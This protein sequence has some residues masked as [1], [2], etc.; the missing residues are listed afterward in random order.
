[1]KKLIV[2]LLAAV[3][4]FSLAACS[5]N[6]T[7]PTN[8]TKPSTTDDDTP[9]DKTADM[10]KSLA[11]GLGTDGYI[12][13]AE[14]SKDDLKNVYGLDTDKITSFTAKKNTKFEDIVILLQVKEGYADKAVEALNK[15]LAEAVNNAR[16]DGNAASQKLLGA[17]LY[18]SGNYVVYVIAGK[19]YV[20]T[21]AAEE[22][23]VA[24]IEYAKVDTIVKGLFGK[25]PKNSAVIPPEKDDQK[26]LTAAELEKKLAAALDKGYLATVEIKKD[27]LK[28]AY[29]LDD[30]Q[31]EAFVAKVNQNGEDV[32]IVLTVKDGYADKAVEALNKAYTEMVKAASQDGKTASQ[33]LMNAR[34]YQEGNTVIFAITGANYDGTDAAAEKTLAEG[35]YAKLDAAVKEAFGKELANVIVTQK[36]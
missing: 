25:L 32:V 17:R 9:T 30:T 31:I 36:G 13:S 16:K 11:E 27:D 28:S 6:T 2:F 29:G 33:K 20:G 24:D 7:K 5:D 12:L 4:L 14:I 21:D 10:D 22:K 34:L 15:V 23:K 35:E 8:P 1:M 3:M 19:S 18:T 26:D